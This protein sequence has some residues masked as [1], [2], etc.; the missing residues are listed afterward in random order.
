M[1]ILSV[2]FTVLLLCQAAFAEDKEAPRV[3]KTGEPVSMTVAMVGTVVVGA[4]FGMMLHAD[5][6]FCGKSDTGQLI[7]GI[8]VVAAGVT[9]TWLGLRSRT[10]TVAPLITHQRVSGQVTVRWGAHD[11]YT[12]NK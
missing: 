5:D 10:I 1:K 8:V 12:S 11:K 6:C 3:I 7:G 2:L 9:M 4:G